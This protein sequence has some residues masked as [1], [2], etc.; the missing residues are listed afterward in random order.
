M[1]AFAPAQLTPIV[2]DGVALVA[3]AD[4]AGQQGVGELR[5]RRRGLF[6]SLIAIL[7]VVVALGLKVRQ[8]DRRGHDERQFAEH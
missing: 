2:A 1:H 7:L 4:R 8:I 6:V 5:F 3:A